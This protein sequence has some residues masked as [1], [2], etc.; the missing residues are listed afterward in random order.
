MQINLNLEL[1]KDGDNNLQN[2]FKILPFL[3]G[4][5]QKVGFWPPYQY[6][7]FQNRFLKGFGSC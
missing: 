3:L 6:E 7:G 4:H 2:F 1:M 5:Q